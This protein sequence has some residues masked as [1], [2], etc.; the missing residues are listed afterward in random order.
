MNLIKTILSKIEKF[1][2]TH[3]YLYYTIIITLWI[4]STAEMIG[5]YGIK[6][7]YKRFQKYRTMRK[8][9]EMGIIN[10]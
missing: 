2:H 1:K 3:K 7:G 9:K 10:E 6:F 5:I 4:T 8:L